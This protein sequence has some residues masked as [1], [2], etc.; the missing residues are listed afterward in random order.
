MSYSSN[1]AGRERSSKTGNDRSNF[2]RQY[3]TRRVTSL[4]TPFLT[5]RR[6]PGVRRSLTPKVRP[7]GDPGLRMVSSA[8]EPSPKKGSTRESTFGSGPT[9]EL[10]SERLLGF[11][12]VLTTGF[13]SS[14]LYTQQDPTTEIPLEP[15]VVIYSLRTPSL[16]HSPFV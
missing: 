12:T 6:K 11:D 8:L 1:I 9:V 7:V 15:H 16:S 13:L 5:S 3:N 2:D 14:S 10:T 4:S